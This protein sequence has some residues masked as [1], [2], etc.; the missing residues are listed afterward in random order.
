M[1][2]LASPDRS[3]RYQPNW[4]ETLSAARRRRDRP[5]EA[6]HARLSGFV[7]PAVEL[8]PGGVQVLRARQLFCPDCVEDNVTT[9]ATN[10]FWFYVNL[11]STRVFFKVCS[12]SDI[13]EFILL[14]YFPNVLPLTFSHSRAAA[15]TKGAGLFHA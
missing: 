6:L 7:A 1:V 10:L 4:G 2:P 15:L 5:Y 3:V 13:A 11:I 14:Q 12:G 8:H 9:L